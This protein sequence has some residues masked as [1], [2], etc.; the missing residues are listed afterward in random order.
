M[1]KEAIEN[2]IKLYFE[3]KLDA[4]EEERLIAL[5]TNNPSK[6]L[7]E[8]FDRC[9]A[10]YADPITFPYQ[11]KNIVW[12][13]IS[14]KQGIIPKKKVKVYIQYAATLFAVL[15]TVALIYFASTR[16]F[17]SSSKILTQQDD[18][19]LL[20]HGSLSIDIQES[21]G[22]VRPL[23]DREYS[24]YIGSKTAEQTQ[25]QFSPIKNLRA[26]HA[27]LLIKTNKGQTHK[28]LLP[29]ATEVWLNSQTQVILPLD[30]NNK[31]RKVSLK[32]EAYFEVAKHMGKPFKVKTKYNTA[33]VLGTH[34]NLYAYA[35]QL[36]RTTLSEGALKVSNKAGEI[37][38]NP[39]EQAYGNEDSPKKIKIDTA[40]V[41]TWKLG[42]FTFNDLTIEELMERIGDWYAIENVT[43]TY[44]T[45]DR[46]SGTFKQTN[47]LKELL[48]HLEEVST[49]KF[50]IKQ[51]GIYVM[52]R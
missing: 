14:F 23:T 20:P 51:R 12:E 31:E 52:K 27:S 16:T 22:Q 25:L 46:F 29:D 13:R 19:Y 7:I 32:G 6:E 17:T 28:L 15:S 10:I 4:L 47:S 26:Q 9:Y 38:L 36:E 30:F 39:G 43:Y 33:E 41:F 11:R 45:Q 3:N 44:K 1:E 37:L 21:N 40:Q 42:Y 2:L 8:V 5:L 24:E 35:G 49:I 50:E 18:I 34:F 48:N